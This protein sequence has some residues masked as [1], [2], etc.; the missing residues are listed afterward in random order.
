MI[1]NRSNINELLEKRF[2]TPQIPLFRVYNEIYCS[3]THY[4]NESKDHRL[5][6]FTRCDCTSG[7]E[8]KNR[9]L[10]GRSITSVRDGMDDLGVCAVATRQVVDPL[11]VSSR[12]GGAHRTVPPPDFYILLLLLCVHNGNM[13]A[14]SFNTIGV[15]EF[16]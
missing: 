2:L 6:V 4:G 7:G 14:S 8:N 5:L 3:Q 1:K 15:V 10:K 13:Y 9:M 12:A 11:L 16:S